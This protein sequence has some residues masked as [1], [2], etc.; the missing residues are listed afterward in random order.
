MPSDAKKK[1]EQKKKEAAKQRNANRTAKQNGVAE[2]NDS[3]GEETADNPYALVYKD[4]S[5]AEE[6]DGVS[7]DKED[8]KS[9]EL[10]KQFQDIELQNAQARSCTGVLS[11]HPRSRDVKVS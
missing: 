3:S 1:R 8:E 6:T 4:A 10:A 2:G 7:K 5:K 11:S 9:V